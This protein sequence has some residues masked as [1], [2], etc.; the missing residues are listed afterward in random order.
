M[1]W[2][3]AVNGEPLIVGLVDED[4]NA[5]AGQG[6][7]LILGRLVIPTRLGVIDRPLVVAS[8]GF[9]EVE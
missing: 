5:I 8:L 7:E 6:G 1:S 9:E 2:A 3:V 4:G